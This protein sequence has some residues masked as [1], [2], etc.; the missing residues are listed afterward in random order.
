M[1]KT[2]GPLRA[3]G[4]FAHGW[5]E[6]ARQE[7]DQHSSNALRCRKFSPKTQNSG[8]DFIVFPGKTHFHRHD[9]NLLNTTAFATLKSFWAVN[10]TYKF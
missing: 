4:F 8:N 6:S 9:S 10:E 1:I 3:V 2:K 7:A 5:L